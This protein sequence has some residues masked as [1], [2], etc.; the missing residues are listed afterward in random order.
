MQ[1][2]SDW[3]STDELALGTEDIELSDSEVSA[4]Y[5]V[6]RGL[7]P[8]PT[9]EPEETSLPYLSY[10]RTFIGTSEQNLRA[11]LYASQPTHMSSAIED[12]C[13]L[14]QSHQQ[15]HPARPPRPNGYAFRFRGQSRHTRQR[16]KVGSPGARRS[17]K[18]GVTNF[19]P[20]AKQ[21]NQQV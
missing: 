3:E 15:E 14:V 21:A 1:S 10:S 8:S 18:S 20:P 4:G 16:Q 19:C 9:S 17:G 6:L 12:E 2:D 11:S 13:R 7:A 5:I